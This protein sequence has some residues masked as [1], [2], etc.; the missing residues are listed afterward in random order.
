MAAAAHPRW[1]QH[2]AATHKLAGS[3]LSLPNTLNALTKNHGIHRT[4]GLFM[5]GADA[6]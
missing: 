5:P 1:C 3:G 4:H 6:E 2:L